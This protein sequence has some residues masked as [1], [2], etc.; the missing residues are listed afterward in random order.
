M[1]MLASWV[2]I[3]IYFSFKISR[4]FYI[5]V[6][7]V[8]MLYFKSRAFYLGQLVFPFARA[9]MMIFL[10]YVVADVIAIDKLF[11]VHFALLCLDC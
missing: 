8:L 4:D 5:F 1:L 3:V 2:L 9:I 6:F 7:C 11:L 10:L